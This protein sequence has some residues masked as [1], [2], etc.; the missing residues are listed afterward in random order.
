MA[1]VS[2]KAYPDATQFDQKS[3]YFDPKATVDNP[4]WFLVDVTFE[5]DLK[6]FVPLEVL[7]KC[8]E[9]AQMRLMQKGNRLSILPVTPKEFEFI[10]NLENE[11]I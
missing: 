8:P 9:L 10:V 2:S 11:L 4:R 7:K 6:Q 3:E 5:K 1:R